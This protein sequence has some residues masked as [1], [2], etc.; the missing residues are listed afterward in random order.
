MEILVETI[1]NDRLKLI[2]NDNLTQN[3]LISFNQLGKVF[4]KDSS[5]FYASTEDGSVS[6]ILFNENEVLY[7]IIRASDI[8]SIIIKNTI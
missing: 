8:K 2:T 4:D 6:K 5:N 7:A 3:Q 1:N